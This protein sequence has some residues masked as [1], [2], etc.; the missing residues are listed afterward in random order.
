MQG[1]IHVLDEHSGLVR[2][3][4][5][6]RDRCIAGEIPAFKIRLYNMSNVR[7]YELPTADLLRGIVFE[8]GPRSRTYFDMIIEFRGG[9]PQ[10]ISKLHQ[11]YMSLQFPLLFVFGQPGFYP[12]LQLKSRDGRGKGKRSGRLFQQYVVTVFCALEQSRLDYIRT[13]QNDLRSD[14]LSGLY[15][16]ISRGDNEGMA[17]GSKII[18]P[19]TFTGGPRYMY[20]HYLDALAICR[21]LGNPQF[22]ITFT[23]NVKWPEIKRYMVQYPD[24]TPADRADVDYDAWTP[25]ALQ[26]L[27]VEVY[28]R[29]VYSCT[30]HRHINDRIVLSRDRNGHTHYRRRDTRVHVMKGESKLDNC[31]VVPYN[32]ALCLAFEA[33]INVEYCGWRACLR[34][35]DFPIHSREPAVQI[36]NVHLENMQCVNFRESDML[37]IIVNLPEKKKTT[38]TEWF[39]YNNENTDGRHLTYLDFPSEFVWYANSKQWQRRQIRTKKSIGRLTYVHPSSGDLF[40]FRMLLCHRKGCKSPID[41]RTVNGQIL[42]NYR[43]ACE[44][45]GLLGDDKE[46]DT[47]LEESTVSATSKE[48]RT[49]F[50]QILIYCDVADPLKLWIKY[51]EAMGDDIPAKI[52]RK[53]K[54]PNYHVN[55]EEL[56]GYILYELEKILNGFGKSMTEF[57][58]QAPPQHLLRDLQ[59]KLLM[60]EKNYKR[61]LLREEAVESVP[62]LN[63]DQRKIFD[64][65]IS[66]STANRHE[67]LFVYG[68]GGTGKTFLWRT[69]ISSLRSHGKIVLAVASSGI[70]SLL[71]PAGRTTHSRFKL[72]LELTDESLCHAKKKSQL[73]NLLVETDLI[74][75]DEAPMNDKRCFETLDRTLRDL[76]NAPNVVF[77][78]KTIVLGGDFRQTL[79]VKKGASKEELIAA[80]IAESHLWPHFKVC[81]LKENM[82][83]LRSGLTAEEKRRSEQFAKW[84]LDVGNGEIGEPDAE[85]E[86]DSSWVTIPPE[87]TVTADEAGMSELIDFIYDD[88]TLKAPTAGSLQEKAI[89]CPKNATADVVN[90]KILSGIEGQSRTYLSN[91]EAISLGGETSETDL[92]YPIEYLNTMTFPGLPPHELELKVG[93]PIMILRNVNLSGGL[94]NGTRM[95][96]RSLMSKLI[97]A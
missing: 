81:T 45:L 28:A 15:D 74:I 64:L 85:N 72:P 3:F 50:S 21:S 13:H 36:L 25:V 4:R 55:T 24:L 75:W 83:L 35:F 94:C 76:M 70:A 59:N 79:P 61:D 97:E 41:V 91:D 92:L 29:G 89:V 77:G 95:I 14:Y 80:S 57:G 96:V 88:T 10:R 42:P 19:R 8:D 1:L 11:S 26:I 37:D 6:A 40:Y 71:L 87:Y 49:L 44:A 68:H 56:Q 53:T 65:I 27:Q 73:G 32:R 67:L 62:K 63:H 9:P 38:L 2:L 82:R 60:E 54:I 23:C 7:G 69:I 47:T 34:I 31:D 78:G 84:L 18:L 58:L 33:H 51:W 48:L 30:F 12:E 5:N 90:A 46:W 66:A 17:A 86:Q 16:A 22:F 20:S 39:V 52:S 93:S 43:A